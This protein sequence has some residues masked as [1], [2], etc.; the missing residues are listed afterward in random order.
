MRFGMLGFDGEIGEG[1]ASALTG[2]LV[3][4]SS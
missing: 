1:S 4:Y 3:G 2:V